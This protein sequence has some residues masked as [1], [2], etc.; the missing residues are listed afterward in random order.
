MPASKCLDTRSAAG[1]QLTVVVIAA[2]Q[3]RSLHDAPAK[4]ELL[5]RKEYEALQCVGDSKQMSQPCGIVLLGS[6][7][8]TTVAWMGATV[9]G[10]G[11]RAAA[12]LA[13]AL[14]TANYAVHSAAAT[15]SLPGSRS[16]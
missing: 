6:R 15:D 14:Y 9:T 2:L 10:A 4:F 7:Q 13:A 11:A 12:G 5:L 8:Q 1:Q 16:R 3:K